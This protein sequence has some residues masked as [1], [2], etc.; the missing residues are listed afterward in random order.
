MA[1]VWVEMLSALLLFSLVFGMSATVE[2]SHMQKQVHNW[3]ALLIG[4]GLQFVVLP[5]CGFLVVVAFSLPAE[6]GI[7]LLVITSSPGGSYSNWWC[8]IFNAELALSVTMTACSTILACIMLPLNLL[9]Y[10]QWTYSAVVVQSL[11]WRALFVSLSVVLG[12]IATGLTVSHCCSGSQERQLMHVRANRLGNCAGLALIFLSFTVSSSNQEAAV[13]DQDLSFYVA[14]AIPVL[15][16][17]IASVSLA[18][19]LE[20]EKPERVAVTIESCLQNTGIA[21]TVALTMFQTEQELA[22]AIGVPLFYGI[23]EAVVIITFCLVCWKLGWTKAPPSDNICKVLATSYEVSTVATNPEEE[24]SIEVVLSYHGGEETNIIFS[25][26]AKGDYIVDE[27]MLS[28]IEKY[29]KTTRRDIMLD[30]ESTEMMVERDDD[31]NEDCVTGDATMA[32]KVGQAVARRKRRLFQ[33][34]P[35]SSD[36]PPSHVHSSQTEVVTDKSDETSGASRST[37]TRERA[38]VALSTLRARA[39][40]YQAQA[41][42]QAGDDEQDHRLHNPVRNDTQIRVVTDAVRVPR[43]IT[44]AAVLA[45]RQRNVYATVTT[46][47]TRHGSQSVDDADGDTL[48][49]DNQ[50]AALPPA[51]ENSATQLEHDNDDDDLSL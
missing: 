18:T 36:Q 34:L 45:R 22:T 26:S 15:V 11:D 8:S 2:M 6:I 17:L 9:V 10:S 1:S 41:P 5:F 28:D 49:E 3:K 23:V 47:S 38:R 16:G 4:I 46:L 13:W 39:T 19:H 42:L 14:C 21:T 7:T 44:P 31:E 33:A 25:Q 35:T 12:G 24:T 32:T 29:Q 20:L 27:Q 43:R 50:N 40:G 37:A 48:Q 30:D 51:V